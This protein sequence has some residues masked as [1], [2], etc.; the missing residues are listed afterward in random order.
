FLS[1][2]YVSATIPEDDKLA[3]DSIDQ[4][5]PIEYTVTPDYGNMTMANG[6]NKGKGW[7]SEFVRLW[8]NIWR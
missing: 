4:I 8:K 2:L 5:E 3:E 1:C 7:W 6:K